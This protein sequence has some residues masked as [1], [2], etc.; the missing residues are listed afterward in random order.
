MTTSVYKEKYRLQVFGEFFNPLNIGN[1]TYG[2]LTLNSSAFGIPTA[3]V[4]QTSTFS[5]GARERNRWG[6][7]SASS[8]QGALWGPLLVTWPMVGTWSGRRWMIRVGFPSGFQVSGVFR[9]GSRHTTTDGLPRSTP[10]TFCCIVL[11]KRRNFMSLLRVS[12]MGGLAP[13]PPLT[14]R[15][16]RRPLES[17]VQS[18][19]VRLASRAGP[20]DLRI[21]AAVLSCAEPVPGDQQK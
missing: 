13:V 2:N 19:V 5:S 21:P 18:I 3:R 15:L 10:P 11:P 6:R 1:L 7:A 8:Q 16:A 9:S 20:A 17:A 12:F 4:G 14:S